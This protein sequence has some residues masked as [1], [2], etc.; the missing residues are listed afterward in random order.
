MI[1]SSVIGAALAGFTGTIA[2]ILVLRE[3][4]V[5]FCGN[6]LSSGVVFFCWLLWTG[7]GSAV[8]GFRRC[9]TSNPDKSLVLTLSLLGVVFPLTLIGIRGARFL[10]GIPLGDLVPPGW[11]LLISLGFSCFLCLTCGALFSLTWAVHVR[12]SPRQAS[13]PM[14]VYAA[15]A[16]GAA[17]AGLLFY[18]VL[19]PRFS[20]LSISWLVS[21]LVIFFA[22]VLSLRKEV[23]LLLRNR[24]QTAGLVGVLGLSILAAGFFLEDLERVSR[25]LQWGD[26][27]LQVVDTPYQNLAVLKNLDQ[28]TLFG[29]GVW[30]FTVPD[31]ETEEFSTH[32]PLLQHPNPRKVLI[33]GGCLRLVGEVLKHP[34]IMLVDCVEPDPAV[35]RLTRPVLEKQ[36]RKPLLD[37]R[38]RLHTMDAIAYLRKNHGESYDVILMN[39]G[40]PANAAT[41]RF[42]TVEYFDRIGRLLTPGGVF[43]F[44]LSAAPEMLGPAQARLIGSADR[45]LRSVFP[46]VILVLGHGA[47]FLAGN[48]QT[49]FQ[50][51]VETLIKTIQKRG[52]DLR[53]FRE[54]LLFDYLSPW[55]L[56]YAHS[57]LEK[58]GVL[59]ENQDFSPTCYFN[60]LVVWAFQLHPHLASLFLFLS[61]RKELILEGLYALVF[62]AFLCVYGVGRSWRTLPYLAS[63]ALV[64]GVQ[65]LLQIILLLGFQILEGFLYKDL[66]LMIAFFMAGAG[67]GAV[68]S[69]RIPAG[70]KS[71]PRGVFA[72]Q[73][74]LGVY[75]LVVLGVLW[76]LHARGL[77][78]GRVLSSSLIFCILAGV[79]GIL[80]GL[81]F[82]LTVMAVSASRIP[83]ERTGGG[84]YAVDLL[85]GSLGALV[86]SLLL[87]PL[88]GIPLTMILLGVMCLGGLIMLVPALSEHGG[89]GVQSG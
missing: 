61:Q 10:L 19:L 75:T 77:E 53:Y 18:Y 68:I 78:G 27:L 47:R 37:G 59:R 35:I 43:S 6:E 26:N 39:V 69:F 56:A 34:S 24:F 88:F 40:D 9:R 23:V 54:Y 80:G 64:G 55:R 73:A 52:L 12:G 71:S 3:L 32:L 74:V 13:K 1:P 38:V 66:C 48:A 7:C 16:T 51:E 36:D 81:H 84:L 5:L 14:L 67:A 15:E 70:P 57:I 41:N 83:S 89:P 21:V 22:W 30:L 17:L 28:Y 2:Q 79:S 20:A 49:G 86:G 4:L 82:S 42:Y 63:V 58:A 46:Q 85:G 31:P 33:V 72:V 60:H 44:S 62:V 11:M 76:L 8:A 25:R 45:T 29:N 87:L 50:L 65:M